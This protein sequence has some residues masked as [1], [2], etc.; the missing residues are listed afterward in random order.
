RA[1][2]KHWGVTI[3]PSGS[4]LSTDG[5]TIHFP[6]NSDDITKVPFQVLNGYLDHEVGHVAEEREH[7]NHGLV[8]PMDIMRGQR[9]PT[10]RML[11]NVFEDIR[12]E[13]KRGKLYP[14]V[15][16]NLKA[17]NLHSVDTF[18][19]RYSTAEG[20]SANFWHTFGCGIIMSA[21]GLDI[22][23]LPEGFQPFMDLV[24]PEIRE[25][26]TT[27]WAQDSIALATR[28]YDKVKGLA[29]ALEAFKEEK[30]KPSDDGGSE[31]EGDESKGEGGKS[32]TSDDSDGDT[33]GEGSGGESG[34]SKDDTDG[35]A[36]DKGD[37]EGDGDDTADGDPTGDA[38]DTEGDTEGEGSGGEGSG[39][40]GT[41]ESDADGVGESGEES[42]QGG[43]EGD[44]QPSDGSEDTDD[45]EA[46]DGDKGGTSPGGKPSGEANDGSMDDGG[47]IPP[48]DGADAAADI[49]P[50][51]FE[52]SDTDDILKDELGKEIQEA[53]EELARSH[54]GY[55]PE[56]K[57]AAKD[58]WLEP[59]KGTQDQYNAIRQA[60]AH[61]TSA[62][63]AKLIRVIRSR[64]ESRV[65][66]DKEH[67]QL[68]TS[69]LH[70][71]RVGNKRV[72]SQTM[73]GESLD[74]AVT[75]LVDQSGSMGG[76]DYP[77]SRA[78]YARM[79]A[80]SLAEALDAIGVPFEVIGWNNT[81]KHGRPVE[82][83]SASTF[84]NRLPFEYYVY[85]SFDE[86]YRTVRR[87]MV[88]ITGLEE[89]VDGEAILAV[90][91][92][93]A[94]RPE[95]RKLMFVISDG[96]PACPGLLTTKG[97]M[98][99]RHLH[100]AIKD[101]RDSGIILMGIGVQ[102]G[103]ISSYY[104]KE[105]SIMINKLDEMATEIFKTVRGAIISGLRRRVA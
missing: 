36:G 55:I 59:A 50:D 82:R 76:A 44:G 29:E 65:Q 56:P 52:E 66:Y 104:G 62:L 79:T 64:T 40:E 9:N 91:R 1:Q 70:Q 17:A 71:L 67:G 96:S 100:K 75:I 43:T 60:V 2:S 54:D 77:G 11:L 87:R 88:S 97:H 57:M 39:D 99:K 84:I 68:D 90:A 92:R 37:T 31:G 35:D 73:Q 20:K 45:T 41:D 95:G 69:A 23:W 24:E 28:V 42:G 13:L 6:W 38:G 89:N 21:R 61:Q 98:G 101:V 83:W 25:S 80:I 51:V 10:K 102:H 26:T 105:F 78:H 4:A 47:A 93:L 86:V 22:S 14:G 103:S 30:S 18:K 32:K 7:R 72:F 74:T 85:K 15:Q 49:A 48:C 16:D 27:T 53:S 63:R 5:E 46:S 33:E 58:K 94:S 3:T 8:T 12:M 81:Y 19:K 34:E